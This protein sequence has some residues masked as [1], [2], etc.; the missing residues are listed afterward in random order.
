MLYASLS[1]LGRL[2][3]S[4]AQD[5]AQKL[6]VPMGV[7]NV[8]TQAIDQAAARREPATVVLLAAVGMQTSDWSQVQPVFLYHI[9][10]ALR[11]VGMEPEARMIAAEALM[12][13]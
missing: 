11:A 8:W 1:A 2:R 6:D 12:R 4:D 3:A 9:L 7:R 10:A 13:T 5:L